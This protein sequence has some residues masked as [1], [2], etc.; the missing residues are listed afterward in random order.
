MHGSIFGIHDRGLL[1]RGLAADLFVF[2]PDDDR[3][4]PPEKI[5][6][7]PEGAP[8]Y[9][10]GGKG[11]HYTV[12]NGSVLDQTRHPHGR[13]S[14]ESAEKRIKKFRVKS[15]RLSQKFF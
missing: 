4:M 2:E 15:I 12:V 5:D 14:G 8:R 13:V 1:R 11:I 3:F 7:L 10:Q 9:I 6:D